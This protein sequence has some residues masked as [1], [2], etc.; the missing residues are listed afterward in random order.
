M[1]RTTG[2]SLAITGLMQADGRIDRK[3]AYAPDQGVPAEEYI[4]ELAARGIR[5]ERTTR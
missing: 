1:E 4:Q 5:I 2:Y 3:G